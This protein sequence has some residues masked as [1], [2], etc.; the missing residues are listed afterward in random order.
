MASNGG[1]WETLRMPRGLTALAAIALA[2]IL[3]QPQQGAAAPAPGKGKTLPISVTTE[4]DAGSTDTMAGDG[5]GAYVDGTNGA[6]SYLTNN[7]CNGLTWGDWRFD[8]QN[9]SRTVGESFFLGDAVGDTTAPYEGTEQQNS[10]MNVQ[11]TCS[12]GVSM[13]TMT[14]GSQIVCPL[15]NN[16]RDGSGHKWSFSPGR[17]FTGFPETTDA[18]ITCNHASGGHCTDWSIDP[19]DTGAVGRVMETTGNPHPQSIDHGDYN[20]RFH[21]HIA[22]Q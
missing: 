9:S 11:C 14:E 1:L 15:L 7:V 10:W 22:L 16:W 3:F 13:Y 18:L 12:A 2:L 4:I 20:M 5:G 17:S 21:I 6:A 8:L 19:P